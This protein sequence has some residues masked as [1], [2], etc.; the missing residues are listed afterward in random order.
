MVDR[1][2]KHGRMFVAENHICFYATILG[3]QTK[4]VIKVS[5]IKNIEKKKLLG[6]L[7]NSIEISTNHTSFFFTYFDKR[8]SAF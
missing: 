1:I 8:D 6:I 2:L 3:I 7:Q 5:D 4:K